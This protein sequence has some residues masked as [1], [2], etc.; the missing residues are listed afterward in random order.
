MT[1]RG[2]I[3]HILTS[4]RLPL[5]DEK[6]LQAEIGQLFLA[7][8]LNFRREVRLSADDIIDFVVDRRCGIEVKIGGA[9]RAIFKQIERYC[10][11]IEISEIVLA[12]NVV[13]NLPPTI[14]SRP[15]AIAQ[16]GRGWL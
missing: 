6:L 10:G 7:H 9:R 4:H 13:M 1:I 11:H 16:L 5:S 14:N 8:R 15:T 2:Q 12:T 3:C